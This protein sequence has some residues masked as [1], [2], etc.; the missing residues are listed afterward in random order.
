MKRL[1]AVILL[2]LAFLAFLA[3]ELSASAAVVTATYNSATD[4]PVT[5]ATY[6]ATGNSVDFTLGYAPETGTE[7]TVVKNTGLS[8][9][10]GVFSNLTHGQTVT[11]N[12]GGITYA[13]VANYYGG[14]GNDLLLVWKNNRPM[15][16]GRNYSGE[17]GNNTTTGSTLPLV[18]MTTD[19]LSGKT[20]VAVAAGY[21]HSM[22]LC[23][24]GTVAAWGYNGSGQLGNN[25]TLDS[26][27][28]VA[29]TAAGVLS[30]KTVVAVSAGSDHSVA[31][32]SDGTLAAWGSNDLGQLGINSRAVSIVPVAVTRN[33]VLFGKTVVAVSA[34][35][36][37][38]LALCSDGTLAAW[39]YNGAGQL[40][41]NSTTSSSAPVAVARNGVLSGKTVVAVSA[42]GNHSMALCSD[43]TV[44]AWG[45]SGSGQ[46]GNNSTLK[47]TVPVALTVT[48]VLS[49]K[50]VVGVSAG[51]DHSVA[52]CSEGT[53]AV[54]GDNYY[55]Q[56]GNN[57]TRNSSVPV[58]VTATGVLSGRTV[59]AVSAGATHTMALLSDGTVA[60]WGYNGLGQLGNNSMA[61]STVPVAVNTSALLPGERFTTSITGPSAYHTLALVATPPMV[62]TVTTPTSTSVTVSTA[63]LG[64]Y[65]TSE[66]GAAITESG[67][68]F[69][70]TAKNSNPSIGG[71]GVTKVTAAGTMGVFTTPVTGLSG[72]T[73]YSFKAYATNSVGKTGYTNVGTFETMLGN[74]AASFTSSTDVP[75][76]LPSVT[77]VSGSRAALTL[78][79][80]PVTGTE[81]TVVNNT[82]ITFINGVFSNLTQGQTVTLRYGG[83]N[84]YFVV[85]YYGGTGND[86]VLIWKNNRLLAW[87]SNQS[88][89][90]GRSSLQGSTVPVAV[91]ATGLLFGKTVLSV[92][93]G[94]SH[95][96]ALCSDGT[97]AAWGARYSGQLGDN[98]TAS[99]SSVPVAVTATGTLAGKTVVSISAGAYHSL[100]LCSD[101]TV[102]AWGSNSYGNLG[103]GSSDASSV[104]AAVV[105]NGVLAG[106]IVVAVSA[107]NQHSLALCSDG[108]VA[109]WGA[110]YFGQ[111]GN[112]GTTGSSVPVAVTATGLLSRKIVVSITAGSYH[113]MALCSDGT[114]AA[115][116]FNGSG[117]LGNASMTYSSVP[118]AVTRNEVLSGKTVV[119]VSAGQS[120]SMALFSDGTMASW[121]FNS[122]G[123]LGN[124]STTDSSVPVAVAATGVLSSKTVV[125]VSVGNEHSAALCSDG[126][127]A[128][129]GNNRYGQLGNNSTTLSI[130]PES[131]SM[132]G[133][134]SGEHFTKTF[135]GSTA[136]HTLALVA[137]PPTP[138][139]VSTPTSASIT[140][141]TASLGG[142]VTSEGDATITERGVVYAA[143][144]TNN[145][146]SIGGTGVTRVTASGT[147]SIFMASVTGLSGGTGYSFKAYAT[148]ALGTSYTNVWTFGTAL[149][150]LPAS[151]TSEIDVPMILP[152]VTIVSRSTATLTLGY[153]PEVGTELTVVNNTG[154]GFISGEFSNLKQGQT[155]TLSYGG[156]DYNFVVNYYGGTG[157]DLVLVWKAN[158]L[159]AWG[160]NGYSQLGNNSTTDSIVPVAVRA[161]G[162]LAG[163]TL[164]TVSAGGD[165]SLALCSDGMVVAWGYNSFGQLGNNSYTN[166]PIPVAVTTTG[167][168]KGKTVVAVSA[169]YRHSMALCSD[170][171]VAEWGS[172]NQGSG[173]IPSS[174][175]KSVPS[176]VPVT[177]VL[178]GK[179]VV[180]ISDGGNHSM[181]LCSDGTVAAWGSNLSGQLGNNS[182]TSST[183]PVA[184]TT[185]GVLSNKN[186]VAVS[187]GENHSMAL[188]SDG[189]MAAWGINYFGQLGSPSSF[190]SPVPLA[191]TR[192]G[193]LLSKTV[194]AISA[195]A[196]HNLALCSD[197]TVAAWGS[198]NTTDSA[199]LVTLMTTGVLVGKIAVAISAGGGHSLV[200]CSDGT[201]AAWGRN[202]NGELGNNSTTSSNIPVAANTS[203][204]LFGE[205]FTKAISGPSAY[206]TLAL[207]ALPPWAVMQLSGNALPIAH[208]DGTPA[209][210][211]GTDFGSTALVNGQTTR[212]FTI[213]NL[214]GAPIHLMGQDSIRIS[215]EAAAE[216]KVSTQPGSQ[217]A[218]GL[219][220]SFAITFVPRFPGHRQ[221][222][223]TITSNSRVANPYSFTIT[224]YGA[225]TI[226]KP[227]T[228]TFSPPATAYLDQSPISL[229][230]IASSGLPVTFTVVSGPAILENNRLKLIFNGTVKVMASQPGGSNFAAANSVTKSIVVTTAP[231]VLTLIS[232]AQTYDG[233]PKPISTLGGT[234][235]VITYSIGDV[236][237]ST[238]PTKAGSYPVKAV[239][240][241]VTKSG[242]LVIAKAILT[243]TP[244]DQRKFVGQ[245]TPTLTYDISGFQDT[246]TSAVLTKAPVIAT[247]ATANSVGGVYPITASAASALNYIFNYQQGS[248]VVESFA[249]TYESL[250]VDAA[251]QPVAKLSI[252]VPTYS[253]TFTAKLSTGSHTS[254]ISFT[255]SLTPNPGVESTTGS[256]TTNILVN[257]VKIPYVITFTLPF[258]GDVIAS[259]T[260]NSAPLG[261]A[262][263]G[264]KLLILPSGKTVKYAGA[265][266]AVL[267]P[268]TPAGQIVPGGA[269]WATATI[270]R[271]GVMTLTGKLGDGTAFTSALSPDD[272]SNPVYRLFM[273]PYL[274]RRT[275][276]PPSS[277]FPLSPIEQVKPRNGPI[278]QPALTIRTE[279]YLA[280]AFA[281]AV[282]PNPTSDISLTNRRY[283][284]QAGL[285]WKK[286]ERA[287]DASYRAGFGP[288]NIVLMLDPWLPPVAAKDATSTANA[289]SAI[290]LANRLG[291]LGPSFEFGVHHS[292][293]GSAAHANLPNTLFLNPFNHWS[294]TSELYNQ[295]RTHSFN[296][297]TGTFTG[298]FILSDV[299]A[300][301]TIKRPVSFSGVFRQPAL[302][303][304]VLIGDGHYILPPLTGTERSTGEIMFT[305]P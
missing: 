279:S 154:L 113:C 230:A 287:T 293:S 212:S 33:G 253:K 46:L 147:T 162:L 203:T 152:S 282:H 5:A 153:A 284:E 263:D 259:A 288:V 247:A 242:T 182:T 302:S 21:Q 24:D 143:T 95:S 94:S 156:L 115:W 103:N 91:T 19:M 274:D 199:G 189:T 118:V 49:G 127:V 27:V 104:P 176:A 219:N 197:G 69:A 10:S 47:S 68:V 11:L 123:Q 44:A 134:I 79:Y 100:A 220:T 200:Q 264:R 122:Y 96:L 208:A 17:L 51:K 106:K 101:G 305:R 151:Y 61:N 2:T 166:S 145:N 9:I 142:H 13:F 42:G 59:V 193:V 148:S 283:V 74:L 231:T 194:M 23:S 18:V 129:W 190:I 188:C 149:G 14:T 71:T 111:L 187:A 22:A 205:S 167:V 60:A 86:L 262:S 38:S 136:N 89:Q 244:D 64:G 82:G 218:S 139:T 97:L 266:T 30:S 213:S 179:T 300:N 229:T 286:T 214:G 207:V 132:S 57:S 256:A 65:I 180:A 52:L 254:A 235:P 260:R 209:T 161:A 169:G 56:L 246:D 40:G 99:Y 66:G 87:G 250:L 173:H 221:A 281:L 276:L 164:V 227:Q 45:Y 31:L 55:G 272:Q 43:G 297:T 6:T 72:G 255:G 175:D 77:I 267:E 204:L 243:V 225:L 146:P 168:L 271:T 174:Y 275:D 201:V 304:D 265:H 92:S 270:S 83:V 78:D 171:T 137:A 108:T 126:T 138:Q 50:T 85:N 202:W 177:G 191:V 131:V 296:P 223:V 32:C 228:I 144:A 170:G 184:V 114:L 105:T 124:N 29:V 183:I 35:S 245:P 128:T 76:T 119:A 216:F 98:S 298:S 303:S 48:G 158:R 112:N 4:V 186:V 62:P 178:S 239:D 291:L 198:H 7:L 215:G 84:Y 3:S 285:T 116:G 90:L 195:G 39:G 141:S 160:R 110:N 172:Y 289:I 159:L 251:R 258:G 54:W 130:V 12:Y 233:T 236:Y 210:E 278:V 133:L 120:H 241:A 226:L 53:V 181:V 107:G 240:G 16:W 93:A 8:F 290:T 217:V 121:G 301:K 81:L 140:S 163:K 58:V 257:K 37:H 70:E 155:V 36:A 206:H 26:T 185:T 268:A 75:V 88:G 295:W 135:T 73:S 273:Q 237:G 232:L 224:G 252:T 211:D 1:R 269:G 261:S 117:E 248:M 238:A 67:I 234:N 15:G 222:T 299:V 80:A 25:S 34:G 249:G 196:L 280:G 192:N 41:N 102:V 150:N 277:I 109:A 157:N 63:S 165:H 125:T 20:V 292:P 294:L 28:P